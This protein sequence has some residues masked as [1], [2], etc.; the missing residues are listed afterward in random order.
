MADWIL[1]GNTLP[2]ADFPW[3]E[4][5]MP[6]EQEDEWVMETPIGATG[7]SST[8]VQRI[9]RPSIKATLVGECSAATKAII[10][11][12]N[13]TTY[14]IQTPF[15]ATG[16]SWLQLKSSFTRWNTGDHQFAVAGSGERFLYRIEL[17]G[18]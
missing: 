5:E 16:K 15:D 17:L 10:L 3:Y 18:R 14:T 12:L 4:S 8:V 13:R 9:G 11:A 7:T 6:E 2:A 1:D